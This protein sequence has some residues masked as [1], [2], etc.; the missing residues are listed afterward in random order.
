MKSVFLF[1]CILIILFNSFI[2]GPGCANIIP[3]EGGPRDSLPPVLIKADPPDSTLNFKGNRIV[4]IFDEFIDLQD[5][6]RNLLFIPTFERNPEIT[7]KLRTLT[8]RLQD[9]LEANTTYTFNFGDAIKDVNESNILRNFTYTFSTGPALDSLT[10]SGKVVL[11]ETGTTDSTLIVVLHRNLNDSAVINNRPRYVTRLDAAGNFTFKNL[12]AGTFAIYAL[13]DAAVRR[14]SR[15]QFFAFKDSNLTTGVDNQPITLYAFKETP[16][17]RTTAT[18]TA[19]SVRSPAIGDKRLRITTSVSGN[20]Q[21]LFKP[22]LISFEQSLKFFDST[23]ISLAVDSTYRIVPSTA[24][25]DSTKKRVTIQ[26]AWQEGAA[27]HLILNKEFAEDTL[28]RKL[29]K[30]DTLNFNTRK[31]SE[32]G[33]L[34]IRVRNVNTAHNPV[35]QFVQNG[36]VVF[37]ASVKSGSFNQALFLPGDYDLRILY[38]R[39][40]NGVWDTGQFFGVKRQPEIVRPLE[41]KIVVKPALD[42][43]FELTL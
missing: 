15:T 5:V 38:D 16:A 7:V 34:S 42:N 23:K 22:L 3:P 8:I 12:P 14:F 20:N 18:T 28:G 10:L 40:D 1:S 27:Y 6:S 9:S 37:S 24:S 13:G 36:V 35:L 25:L 29:L 30:T 32:Y 41:R 11:A 31:N 26:T 2:T 33:N 17:T 21:D 19:P 4:L 39:N 43:E